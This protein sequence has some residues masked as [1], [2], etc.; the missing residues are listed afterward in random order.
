MGLEGEELGHAQALL[1]SGHA[2]RACLAMRAE[3]EQAPRHPL[4]LLMAAKACLLAGPLHLAEAVIYCRYGNCM[5]S[6]WHT[7]CRACLL[8]EYMSKQMRLDAWITGTPE[9]A[10]LSPSASPKEQ[11]L[12]RL[13]LLPTWNMGGG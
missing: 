2:A 6:P 3:L 13:C 10:Q 9:K 1:S 4:L 11:K 8:N 7:A 12:D 5:P